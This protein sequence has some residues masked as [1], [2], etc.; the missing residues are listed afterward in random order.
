MQSSK[1]YS[2]L[3]KDC[4]WEY[5]FK[6]SDIVNMSISKDEREKKFLFEKILLNSTEML[7][8]M[9]IFDKNSLKKL[10]EEYKIPTFNHDYTARRINILE[11]Y[12]LNKTL[13]VKKEQ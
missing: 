11:Y 3:L 8:S 7:K 4:F 1:K 13:T 9:E 2:Q 12:F 6:S 5:D 10:I